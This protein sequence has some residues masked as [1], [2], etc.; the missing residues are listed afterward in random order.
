MIVHWAEQ[1]GLF[2]VETDYSRSAAQRASARIAQ[3]Q[4]MIDTRIGETE[5]LYFL[6][7]RDHYT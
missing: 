5:T 7:S 6:G 3:K 2:F 1:E 4:F